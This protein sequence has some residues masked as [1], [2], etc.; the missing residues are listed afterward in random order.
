MVDNL[1]QSPGLVCEQVSLEKEKK[2]NK[3]IGLV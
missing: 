3:G 2:P 1:T